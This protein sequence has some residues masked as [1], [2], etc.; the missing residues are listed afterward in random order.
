MVTGCILDVDL[1]ECCLVL[2]L[3]SDLMTTSLSSSSSSL[4]GKAKK[5][6]TAA[7]FGGGELPPGSTLL[8]VVEHKTP[9]YF[10]VS[11]ST[12]AGSKLAYGVM[13]TVS[14]CYMHCCRALQSFLWCILWE[15]CC[16]Q[17]LELH[18]RFYTPPIA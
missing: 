3:N 8:A 13:D 10:I 18:Q 14:Q 2:S 12:I 6:A 1:V 16:G 4:K 5:K 11:C 17:G 7:V 9:H 15:G